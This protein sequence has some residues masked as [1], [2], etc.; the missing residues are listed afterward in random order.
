MSSLLT[1][2]DNRC[3]RNRRDAKRKT[4]RAEVRMRNDPGTI[5]APPIMNH[6]ALLAGFGSTAIFSGGLTG[7][8]VADVATGAI[9]SMRFSTGSGAFEIFSPI[10]DNIRLYAVFP[11]CLV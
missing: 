2:S 10:S 6:F 7:N 3:D 9:I 11:N 4:P 5:T 1:H 8:G